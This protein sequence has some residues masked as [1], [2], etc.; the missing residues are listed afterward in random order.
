MEEKDL[1]NISIDFESEC[2]HYKQLYD[3]LVQ[4]SQSIEENLCDDL[5]KKEEENNK[6]KN[7]IMTL[8]KIILELSKLLSY[9]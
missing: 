4:S 2:K 6:L 9:E 1:G 3:N 5:F 7:E 8:R